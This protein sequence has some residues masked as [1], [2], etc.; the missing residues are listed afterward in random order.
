MCIINTLL[1]SNHDQSCI[2]VYFY[3]WV[4]SITLGYIVNQFILVLQQQRNEV[5]LTQRPPGYP[6]STQ[7][8]LHS[9][10][11]LQGLMQTP[12][13]SGLPITGP[14]IRWKFTILCTIFIFILM[15]NI[16]HI[17]YPRYSYDK[18]MPLTCLI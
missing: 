8:K 5:L 10:G 12:R 9:S 1:N 4:S 16:F 11:L 15:W 6:L 3:L 7:S 17:N 2:Q 18:K 13:A 14:A